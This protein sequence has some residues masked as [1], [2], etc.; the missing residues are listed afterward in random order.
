MDLPV[1]RIVCPIFH[2]APPDKYPS[3][4]GSNPRNLKNERTNPTACNEVKNTTP[5]AK[6][7]QPLTDSRTFMPHTITLDR[8]KNTHVFI[9]WITRRAQIRRLIASPLGRR[10]PWT[11][12][13]TYFFNSLNPNAPSPL[14]EG[15]LGRHPLVGRHTLVGWVGQAQSQHTKNPNGPQ[16]DLATLLHNTLILT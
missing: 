15:G 9:N 6:A 13:S 11:Q 8:F 4:H 3:N 5:H 16:H 14:Y 2:D 12:C 7:W 10:Q 1:I